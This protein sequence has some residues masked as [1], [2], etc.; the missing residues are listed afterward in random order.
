MS[1]IIVDIGLAVYP[2]IA[3]FCLLLRGKMGFS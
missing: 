1:S 2:L 3:G